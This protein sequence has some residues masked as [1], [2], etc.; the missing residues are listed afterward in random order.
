MR[1]SNA[2]QIRSLGGECQLRTVAK[3]LEVGHSDDIAN[4]RFGGFEG[5][6]PLLDFQSM[7]EGFA[8]TFLGDDSVIAKNTQCRFVRLVLLVATVYFL[9][10]CNLN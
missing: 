8:L 10:D 5:L 2:P 7:T 3:W 1:Y 4:E 6:L 9:L